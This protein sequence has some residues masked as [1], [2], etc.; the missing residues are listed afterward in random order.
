MMTQI[1]TKSQDLLEEFDV[2][3]LEE[4]L[5]EDYEK[6]QQAY[7][8]L[9]YEIDS[10]TDWCGTL[11]RVWKNRC[12]LGTFYQKRGNWFANPYFKN[13]KYLRLDEDLSRT[14]KSNELAIRHIISSFGDP[15]VTEQKTTRFR[16]IRII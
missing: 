13:G 7:V 5:A 12:L 2:I 8:E 11:Y 15:I 9:N 14:W 4:K 10:E 1:Q 6:A 3:A 16:I